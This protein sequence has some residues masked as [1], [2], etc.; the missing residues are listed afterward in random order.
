MLMGGVLVLLMDFKKL[1][2]SSEYNFLRTNERLGDNVIL[3]TLGGS[4]A[5]GT[6]TESSDVDIRGCALNSPRDL[7]GHGN[8]EQVIDRATDTTIYAFNKLVTLLVGCNPNVI[9]MLG[10]KPEHYLLLTK[11]G[12]ALL[13]NR[14]LFLSKMAMHS[15]GGYAAQQLR[16]MENF[17]A[18]DEGL[19]QS[20]KEEH[21]LHALNR[22]KSALEEQ[23]E[24][25]LPE[26]VTMYLDDSEREGFDV[27][28][29]ADIDLKHY[30][31]RD[32]M[33]L[34]KHL[35]NVVVSYQQTGHRNHKKDNAHLNKHAMH[36]V[37]LFL[38]GIDILERE[39]IITYRE[40][41][42]NLLR[43]IRNGAF[44]KEDGSYR[45]EFFDMVTDLEARLQYAAENT[46]LPPTP[47]KKKVEDFVMAVNWTSLDRQFPIQ[48][49]LSH[50]A[51]FE[52]IEKTCGPVSLGQYN[53]LFNQNKIGEADA[54]KCAAAG[55]FS[56]YV[57]EIPKEQ[58][59]G[60]FLDVDVAANGDRK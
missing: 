50:V 7:I 34:A 10:C 20:R 12:Q 37:R 26:S 56:P 27:E 6:N 11:E 55:V 48:R 23:R 15:F 32:F 58:Y 44:Q 18:R 24:N 46:S 25:L 1:L 13:D 39:E 41:D 49:N 42:L 4:Y 38:M 9:E 5:Y 33:A 8:F 45:T 59:Q 19:P 29:F 22:S 21:I 43:S 31:V 16:R 17:L 47:D 36:L 40:N 53:V 2:Q 60:L 14:K 51:M 52:G 57:L 28:T 54:Y 3:L 30:P 35:N